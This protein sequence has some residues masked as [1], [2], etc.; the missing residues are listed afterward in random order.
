MPNLAVCT[1]RCVPANVLRSVLWHLQAHRS[2]DTRQIMAMQS[3][4]KS[5]SIMRGW[6]LRLDTSRARP[7]ARIGGRLL[8]ARATSTS[9]AAQGSCL[10]GFCIINGALSQ[11][12]VECQIDTK[13]WNDYCR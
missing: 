8:C 5:A 2:S 9:V 4:Y 13:P 7:R 6:T 3:C 1:P 12:A 11:A 10:L